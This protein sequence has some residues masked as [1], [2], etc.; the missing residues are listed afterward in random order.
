MSLKQISLKSRKQEPQPLSQC[1][2][3]ARVRST[4]KFLAF[5]LFNG[6]VESPPSSP[7]IQLPWGPKAQPASISLLL[8]HPI[9]DTVH[10]AELAH[11]F[12]P[13]GSSS[14]GG[15]GR[16]TSLVHLSEQ[17]VLECVWVGIYKINPSLGVAGEGLL[18]ISTSLGQNGLSKSAHLLICT[19]VF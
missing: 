16:G 13:L 12:S 8:L 18:G 3:V 11:V 7:S 9:V 19:I 14:P 17:C 15:A 10:R 4:R 5:C 2:L 6:Q 1:S